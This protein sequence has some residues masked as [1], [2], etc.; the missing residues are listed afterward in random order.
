MSEAHVGR[1]LQPLLGLIV[2]IHASSITLQ[3]RVVHNTLILQITG[4]G[5]V[6]QTVLHT[7]DADVV[8][9]TKRIVEGLVVPVIG[10]IVVLTVAVA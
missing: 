1:E 5:V 8:L 4:T 10:S 3:L 2:G 7:A 6:V 9:L